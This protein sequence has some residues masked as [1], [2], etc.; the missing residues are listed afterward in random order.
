MYKKLLGILVI[1]VFL[2]ISVGAISAADSVSVKV[3]W[4]GDAPDHVTVNLIKDGKVVDSAQLSASNSWKTTFKVDDDG[5]YKV[6]EIV[7]D[8]YSYSV[9]GNANSGFVI[10]NKLV[11]TADVLGASEDEAIADSS[12]DDVLEDN[13]SDVENSTETGDTNTTDDS[14]VTDDTNVTDDETDG[15][16][17]EDESEEV[18]E[19][20]TTTITEHQ[21]TKLVKQVDKKKPVNNTTK[22]KNRNT[23]FP[24][25]VLVCAVFAAAFVPF[26]RKK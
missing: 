7:S 2:I 11:K 10:S 8:D 1:A 6:S 25:A 15:T 21:V 9:S 20:I 23:G 16:D 22:V 18:N 3:T 13:S 12:A 26:T 5:L 19:T 4:D 14:N 17:T 24:V